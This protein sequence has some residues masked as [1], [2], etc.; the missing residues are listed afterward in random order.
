MFYEM[1]H[2]IDFIQIEIDF[3]RFDNDFKLI[4]TVFR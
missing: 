1:Y 4:E 3:T 2:E